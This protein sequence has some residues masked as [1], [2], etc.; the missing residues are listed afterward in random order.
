MDF[1][2]LAINFEAATVTLALFIALL[3]IMH[4]RLQ[5]KHIEPNDQILVFLHG[6][7]IFSFIC[8]VLNSYSDELHAVAL[9]NHR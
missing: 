8:F 1:Q 6:L 2:F 7:L 4:R 9:S 3:K 5:G